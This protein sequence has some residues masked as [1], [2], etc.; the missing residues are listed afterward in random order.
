MISALGY[1]DGQIER[2]NIDVKR[3]SFSF[4]CMTSP[5][6]EKKSTTGEIGNFDLR[7]PWVAFTSFGGFSYNFVNLDEP[8][9]TYRLDLKSRKY[10]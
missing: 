7:F 4:I 5:S 10:L 3:N 1:N 9:T 6:E 2:L 8:T